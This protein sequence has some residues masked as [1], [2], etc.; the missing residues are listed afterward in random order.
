MQRDL[1]SVLEEGRLQHAQLSVVSMGVPGVCVHL[2]LAMHLECGALA[3]SLFIAQ[4]IITRSQRSMWLA[5][6]AHAVGYL[7]RTQCRS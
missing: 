7:Q 5:F 2:V 4:H 1:R 6:S 3:H